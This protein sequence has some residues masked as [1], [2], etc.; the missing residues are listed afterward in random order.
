VKKDA[1]YYISDIF[2]NY[3][4]YFCSKSWFNGKNVI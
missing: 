4:R 3:C 2:K 1:K